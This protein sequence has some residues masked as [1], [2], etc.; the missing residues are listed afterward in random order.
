M[1]APDEPFLHPIPKRWIPLEMTTAPVLD[2]E[3]H[4]ATEHGVT[5]HGGADAPVRPGSGTTAS[6]VEPGVQPNVEQHYALLINP[7]YPKDAHASLASMCSPPR[8]P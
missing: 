6:P 1:I 3:E 5:E 2:P 7:F 4:G 8:S